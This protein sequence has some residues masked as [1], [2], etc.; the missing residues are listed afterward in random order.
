MKLFTLGPVQMYP[1]TLEESAK[2]IPYFRTPEFSEIL[3]ECEELLKELSF[4]E[5]SART[6]FL[7]TSGTGAMEASIINCLTKEDRALVIDGG[8]F[9]HRFVEMCRLHDIPA[10]VIKLKDGEVLTAEHFKKYDDAG[11]TAVLVNIDETSTGQ[12]YPIDIISDFC[13]R[14]GNAFLIVD[15]ISSFLVDEYKTAEYGIDVTIISSQKALA[16]APGLSAVILSK[17]ALEER[18]AVIESGNMYMD[19]KDHL[20]NGDRGQTPFTPA[21]G[22][23]LQLHQ[24]LM[25]IKEYGLNNVIAD[26][27]KLAQDFRERVTKLPVRLPEYPLS[28]ACTPLIFDNNAYDIYERLKNEYG[29]VITPNGGDLKDRIVRVGHLGNHTID[30]N[31][32]LVNA[33][34][35]ILDEEQA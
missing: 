20:K 26:A 13:K 28:N 21:V 14:N 8:S 29:L 4:A 5:K 11:I 3:L 23:I 18:V 15:A 33:L 34:T 12:L 19:F 16:L 32:E 1:Y 17:R 9:G 10:E 7:T 27:G 24:R 2:Q 22:V 25:K 6:V 31:V 30:D 35:E